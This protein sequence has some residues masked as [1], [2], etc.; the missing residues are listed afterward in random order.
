MLP[1]WLNAEYIQTQ[2]RAH[3]KNVQL[4]VL[5]LWGKPATGKG[6]NFIGTVTRIHVDYDSGGSGA[7]QHQSYI[8]KQPSSVDAPQASI[9]FE[10]DVYAREMDMYDFVLP[11]MA[12]LLRGI[13]IKEK[14]TAD[15]VAVDR[16]HSVLILEDLA[17]LKY[18]NA[19]R[20][21]QLDTA[22]AKLVLELQAKFHAAAVILRE[23]HP[24]LLAKN[25]STHFFCREKQGYGEIFTSLFESFMGYVKTQ[26]KLNDRYGAKL[27][28]VLS[29]LMEYAARTVDVAP[30]DFQTLVHGDCWT[31]NVMF[32]YDDKGCPVNVVLLDFQFCTWTS[33]AADLHYFC[34]SSLRED[35]RERETQL[36][37]LHY[38]ALTKILAK[39]THKCVLPSLL[40][41][42]LQ[43]ERR[44]FMSF[45]IAITLQPLMLY[46]GT[47]DADFSYLYQDTPKAR[48]FR[49]SMFASEKVQRMVEKMLPVADAK[50]LL[51]PQ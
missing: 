24:E 3:T 20:L 51:Q 44:R 30:E 7:A 47:E 26:P 19:D 41:Y 13:G 29:N 21:K 25:F 4:R 34:S 15:C 14:L 48:R 9:F 46:E 11:R 50:G 32:Q 17:P 31:N 22:H 18:A 40:E 35:A 27:E 16:Q 36:V 42:Q 28:L 38:C 23:R 10:Y 2:L 8:L 45:V 39:F 1:A 37:Q 6:E 5:K 12:E 49:D 43:F 33:P